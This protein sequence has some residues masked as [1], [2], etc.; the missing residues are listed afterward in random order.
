MLLLL[1]LLLLLAVLVGSAIL[2]TAP[3]NVENT[4][5]LQNSAHK[6]FSQKFRD[7]SLIALQKFRESSLCIHIA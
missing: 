6:R 3:S 7:N 5:K 1:L 4:K 2:I